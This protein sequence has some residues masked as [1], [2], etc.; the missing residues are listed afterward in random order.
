MAG[1]KRRKAAKEEAQELQE[2]DGMTN[3]RSAREALR[4]ESGI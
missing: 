4:F 2:L 3:H 1:S